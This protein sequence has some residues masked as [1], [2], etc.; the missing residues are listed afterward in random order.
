M[1]I[2]KMSFVLHVSFWA[3]VCVVSLFYNFWIMP[4]FFVGFILAHIMWTPLGLI[5]G[6][7][8]PSSAMFDSSSIN[9]SVMLAWFAILLII[10]LWILY[11]AIKAWQRNA[12]T[13]LLL[14]FHILTF[15]VGVF[16]L[17][18]VGSINFPFRM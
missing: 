4:F 8:N 9:T 11:R 12:K 18:V 3:F 13:G 1:Q 15:F 2:W 7:N 6:L 17:S 14:I 5:S 16:F 10:S